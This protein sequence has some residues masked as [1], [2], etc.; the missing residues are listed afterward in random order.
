M[1]LGPSPASSMPT[2][3]PLRAAQRA[4]PGRETPAIPPPSGSG[5]RGQRPDARRRLPS[6]RGPRGL[7]AKLHHKGTIGREIGWR[8][9]HNLDSIQPCE[10][11]W[12]RIVTCRGI[13]YAYTPVH[14]NPP[15]RSIAGL[16]CSFRDL[17]RS[18]LFQLRRLEILWNG[19]DRLGDAL[20]HP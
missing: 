13:G 8:L 15:A 6:T 4:T 5:P 10:P 7:G 16:H 1:G 20:L 9:R 14:D 2:A 3:R 12:Y 18:M 11:L 17:I 19:K